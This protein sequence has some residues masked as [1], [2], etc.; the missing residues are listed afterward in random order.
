ME[1]SNPPTPYEIRQV[2]LGIESFKGIKT[3]SETNRANAEQQLIAEARKVKH[4]VRYINALIET[5]RLETAHINNADVYIQQ[6]EDT[7]KAL[8][9]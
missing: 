4:N 1:L 3:S 9:C 8:P 7:L 6:Y 2:K 5:I